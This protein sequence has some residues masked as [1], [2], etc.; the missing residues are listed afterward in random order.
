[1]KPTRNHSETF[2]DT[3]SEV[4]SDKSEVDPDSGVW[5]QP[6]SDREWWDP[7]GNRWHM[8]GHELDPKRT[9]HLLKRSDVHVLHCYGMHPTEVTGS[10]REELLASIEEFFNGNAPP[11]SAFRL[12][13]FRNDEGAAMLVVEESC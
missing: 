11:M 7:V 4:G 2:A 1:V 3:L 10:E 13:E 12:A 6:I 8:R 9:H 5:P